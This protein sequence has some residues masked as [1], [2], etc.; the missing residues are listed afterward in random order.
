MSTPWQRR[1]ASRP[2]TTEAVTVA[3]VLALALSGCFLSYGV[4]SGPPPL[5]P[6]I[7]LS[8]LACAALPR[9]RS[10]PFRVLAVTALC[11]VA[12]SAL[13]HLI[14]AM[15]MA[16]LM[17]AQYSASLR[18]ERRAAWYGALV[19]TVALVGSGLFHTELRHQWLIGLVN[20]AAWVP[21]SA[22]LGSYVR[23]RREYAAARTEHMAREREEEARH[24]VVQERMR[25]ARE[26]HDVVA[27][28]LTLANAQAGTAT[29]LARSAP[30]QAYEILSRLSETTAAALRE[31]KSTVG[32]LRQDTDS[33]DGLAPAPGLDRLPDLVAACAAADLA[34]TVTVEGDPQ[35]LT[36]GLD[37]TAYRIVQEAL[38][39]VTKHAGSRTA[40]VRLAHTPHFLTLT[41]TND[42]GTARP[43]LP[44]GPDH[45]FG[46]LGM[47]ERALAAGGSLHAGPRPE[48]GFEVSCTLPLHGHD[49]S[50]A[51]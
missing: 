5:W 15:T 21:L 2:R 16:P 9:R 3:T 37:L 1:A 8:A 14:T 39:N 38:T 33:E 11:V 29:H 44:P 49:E 28:H 43:T 18:A 22:A 47:R 7:T 35:P 12:V 45:G 24:R 26:L 48:G 30:D 17:V 50:T 42:T 32:L 40:R 36:P 4:M 13:G 23:V 46:L 34:V 20:P 51:P 10:A 6:G 27:H 41:V 31:L 25:I 19:V